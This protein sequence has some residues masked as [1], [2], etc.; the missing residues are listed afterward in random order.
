MPSEGKDLRSR[1]YGRDDRK[2]NADIA[3]IEMD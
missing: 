2:L 3:V 1:L